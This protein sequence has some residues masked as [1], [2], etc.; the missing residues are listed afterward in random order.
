MRESAKEEF[1]RNNKKLLLETLDESRKDISQTF[2]IIRFIPNIKKLFLFWI[3]LKS[4]QIL[5][6]TELGF[7]ELFS[8]K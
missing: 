3:N 1:Y 7:R 5:L 6:F 8:R 2:L 4:F